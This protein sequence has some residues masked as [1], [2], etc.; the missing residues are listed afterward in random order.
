MARRV[1]KSHAEGVCAACG[2]GLRKQYSIR[3]GAPSPRYLRL[4]T[5]VFE[6]PFRVHEPNRHLSILA[7]I[8]I[9]VAA[10]DWLTKALAVKAAAAEPIALTRWLRLAIVHNDGTAFGLSAGDY[11]WA[12]NLALTLGAIALMLPVSRDLSLIDKSAP[13]ALGLI[14][15]GALG[16][17]ASLIFGPPGVVDFIAVAVSARSEFILNVADVAAYVG[18]AMLVRTGFLIVEE[19]RHATR[20]K[21]TLQV[22]HWA[23]ATKLRI[24]D[25][26]VPMT[27][28]IADLILP[29]DEIM[30]PRTDIVPRPESVRR[31]ELLDL[32]AKVDPKVIDIR[33]HL[34][35]ARPE[36][37]AQRSEGLRVD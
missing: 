11:T 23:T 25:R 3:R 19:M 15:G 26:E 27:A 31:V 10:V 5:P 1:L 9:G 16:N 7:R 37:R 35:N 13:R 2:A 4:L 21:A 17:L 24:S 30:V 14:M 12:L 18:F 34:A 22:N 36:V 32:E 20:E 28:P 6:M 33:P 29:Q 8:A